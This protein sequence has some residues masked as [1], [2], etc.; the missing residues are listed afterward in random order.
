MGAWML[1]DWFYEIVEDKA[2]RTPQ[3]EG[4]YYKKSDVDWSRA[5][6]VHSPFFSPE[7]IKQI[8]ATHFV[9]KQYPEI[10]IAGRTFELRVKK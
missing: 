6:K 2:P 8:F 5:N 4:K 7:D 3:I 1:N 9:G 10:E